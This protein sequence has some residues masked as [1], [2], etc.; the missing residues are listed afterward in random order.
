M[1]TIKVEIEEQEYNFMK[2][3][4][5][6]IFRIINIKDVSLWMYFDI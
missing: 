3:L 5:P 1:K 2:S 4:V 6:D